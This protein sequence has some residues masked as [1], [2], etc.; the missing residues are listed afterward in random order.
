MKL[1]IASSLLL[2]VAAAAQETPDVSAFEF[3]STFDATSFEDKWVESTSDKYAG[4]NVVI[5]SSK[6]EGSENDT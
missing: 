2:A 5:K 3:A 6:V 4:Q 1:L